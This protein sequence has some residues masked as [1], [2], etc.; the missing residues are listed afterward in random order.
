MKLRQKRISWLAFLAVL[1]ICFGHLADLDPISGRG[2]TSLANHFNKDLQELVQVQNEAVERAATSL[3]REKQDADQETLFKAVNGPI[4][5]LYRDKRIALLIYR[6][7]KLVSWSDN[8]VPTMVDLSSRRTYTDGEVFNQG[9]GWYLTKVREQGVYSIVSLMLLKKDFE[10]QN[11]YLK[12]NFNPNLHLPP[13]WKI[14]IDTLRG[15]TNIPAKL[16]ENDKALFYLIPGSGDER[17]P[18]TMGIIAFAIGLLLIVILFGGLAAWVGDKTKPLI[19]WAFLA[20]TLI[21]IRVV[22]QLFNYPALLCQSSLFDPAYYASSNILP[23]LGDLLLNV[24]ILCYLAWYFN[25]KVLLSIGKNYS[26]N[27]KMIA[28]ASL[29]LIG[30]ILLLPIGNLLESL[31]LN[32]SISF[33]LNDLFSLDIFS[34]AGYLVSAILLLA[35][36][37]AAE[38]LVAIASSS[39][40]RSAGLSLA[41]AAGVFVAISFALGKLGW[42][43]IICILVFLV[44]LLEK[45]LTQG[46]GVFGTMALLLVFGIFSSYQFNIH[47]TEKEKNERIY[48]AGKLSE[49]RD[50]VAEYLFTEV[51][52]TLTEDRILKSYLTILP[53]KSE[54]FTNRVIQD[55]LNDYRQKY[56]I[57]INVYNSDD[58]L[59]I[60]SLEE[61][62]ERSYYTKYL[63]DGLETASPYLIYNKDY[64]DKLTYLARVP[65]NVSRNEALH[66]VQL[67]IEFKEKSI[68]PESGF[69]ELLIDEKI[70]PKYDMEKYS[71]ARYVN[72]NLTSHHGVYPYSSRVSISEN[73][74]AT[75]FFEAGQ[76]N[77][78]VY[79]PNEQIQIIVSK[80][81][82]DRLQVL[83]SFSF[84]FLFYTVFIVVL[85][86]FSIY[87]NPSKYLRDNF[88]NRINLAILSVLTIFLVLIGGGT[89]YYVLQQND[90]KN[91]D[92]LSEKMQ[93]VSTELGH[94]LTDKE[95]LDESTTDYL[96]YILT[97]FSKVFF[98]D[99]NLYDLNGNL[100]ASSRSRIFDENLISQKMDEN[101][102]QKVALEGRARFIHNENIGKLRY[103][104]SYVPFYNDDDKL[105]AYINLPFFA[106]QKGLERELQSLLSALINA[107]VL[108]ILLA[109]VMTLF[110]TERISQP[111]RVISNNLRK[112]KLGQP[113]QPIQWQSRDEIGTLIS[114]YNRVI[115]ELQHSAELLAKS[116]RES[117]WREMAKQVAHEIKNPLT[118]MKLS[119]QQLQRAYSEQKP[120]WDKNIEKV[121]QVLIEQ[122]DT[123]S[124]IAS[125]FSSFAKMPKPEN[126]LV[127]IALLLENV[128]E[129]YKESNGVSLNFTSQLDAGTMIFADEN[130]MQRAF[131][132]LV[133]NAIQAIPDDREGRIDISLELENDFVL[134]KI[135]DNGTGID[136]EVKDKIFVPNFTTK[137]GGMGLGLAMVRNIIESAAG[138]IWF[139]TEIGEGTTFF[140]RLKKVSGE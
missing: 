133:Q 138:E 100:L 36:Y 13:D 108:L 136:E 17:E 107:Y 68:T 42:L 64:T 105:L 30:I 132:N 40:L 89:I 62:P 6:D 110:I 29:Y 75:E 11:N 46:R 61:S 14:S 91:R 85:L 77:H 131:N 49:D 45:R 76:H 19:G 21:L 51:S 50:P 94:K 54:D 95:Q 126:K 33:D 34:I 1:L 25:K 87:E 10:L 79:K 27:S 7:Q 101:A 2:E 47:L 102:F 82:G 55:F 139:E 74:G 5:Y 12:N 120:N 112:V 123:L 16:S 59:L 70:T 60:S 69:L 28:A 35:Y 63:R 109:I 96:T 106:K 15:S 43:S 127:N 9:N 130:Q 113:N 103:L 119:V 80:P 3:S 71:Y 23:S 88:K 140:I 116:E 90:A 117:A 115:S 122:I 37:F 81:I 86:L 39:N 129:L 104:S 58:S 41:I 38:K 8:H 125:E 134:I 32:S 92:L 114:E 98:A 97:K 78:L 135:K 84:I 57:D 72:G 4:R 56:D 66:N 93:S 26:E 128:T 99:I 44:I 65:F 24:S 118:P 83:T 124:N 20:G 67:F 53:A 48:K 111:L 22:M 31:V 52:E 18:S 137:T 73:Q 121:T